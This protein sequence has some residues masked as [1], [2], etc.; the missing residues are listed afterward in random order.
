MGFSRVFKTVGTYTVWYKVT[1]GDA[2]FESSAKITISPKELTVNKKDVEISRMPDEEI[3]VSKGVHYDL[4]GAVG[5]DNVDINTTIS[6]DN[7]INPTKVIVEYTNVLKGTDKDN[8]TLK[9]GGTM[10]FTD[11]DIPQYVLTKTNDVAGTVKIADIPD[12][13]KTYQITFDFKA[14]LNKTAYVENPEVDEYTGNSR[15]TYYSGRTGDLQNFIYFRKDFNTYDEYKQVTLV[16]KP[17]AE[18]KSIVGIK[19]A[20]EGAFYVNVVDCDTFDKF[21]FKNVQVTELTD[22]KELVGTESNFQHGIQR[23][24]DGTL[25]A[26]K[27]Y[28][29]TCKMFFETDLVPDYSGQGRLYLL[30]ND[31]T[32]DVEKEIFTFAAITDKYSYNQQ[33]RLESY[34]VI[35]NL[36]G[37]GKYAMDDCNDISHMS[38]QVRFFDGEAVMM[39]NGGWLENEVNELYSGEIPFSPG[40]MKAPVISSIRNQCD[41]IENDAELSKLVAAIDSGSTS[42]NGE[43]YNVSQEDFDRVYDARQL[44]YYAGEA[45][46]A[47]IPTTGHNPELA[48]EFLKFMYSDEGVN[49][50]L[51]SCSGAVLPIEN[52]DYKDNTV[53]QENYTDMQKQSLEQLYNSNLFTINT[54]TAVINYGHVKVA[55][56]NANLEFNLS[57]V[58]ENDRMSA[59]EMYDQTFNYYNADDQLN[60]KNLLRSKGIILE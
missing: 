24:D 17:A 45:H 39:V 26:S 55:C 52:F 31:G 59:Q 41:S 25:D 16:V 12:H 60:W 18:E 37:Y 6:L 34:T 2:V 15:M 53:I 57:A 3:T 1:R 30:Y 28:T 22:Y 50:Y 10:E 29:M 42:L 13:S 46:N 27:T 47:F 32:G 8:Y 38:S 4:V 7:E 11:I 51:N 9:Q 49:A 14:Q 56:K 43:G 36:I 23:L 58:N 44:L 40:L 20:E 33:G 21:F 5:S 54:N 35:E 19:V 48:K